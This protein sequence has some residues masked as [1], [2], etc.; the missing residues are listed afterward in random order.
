MNVVG[1]KGSREARV[2]DWKGGIM[3]RPWVRCWSARSNHRSVM[4]G[5]VVIGISVNCA[6]L[7]ATCGCAGGPQVGSRDQ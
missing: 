3:I 1:G 7:E 2:V 4:L 6:M 5:V